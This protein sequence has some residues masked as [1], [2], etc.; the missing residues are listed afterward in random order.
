MPNGSA[1]EEDFSRSAQL[2]PGNFADAC[3]WFARSDNCVCMIASRRCRGGKV[4]CPVCG[5][6]GARFL[7][8]R[9]VWE[10]KADHP[11]QQ[12]SVR[13]GTL[14]EDLV[15]ADSTLSIRQYPDGGQPLFQ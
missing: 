11:R 7:A 13:A 2:A 8:T 9:G 12:F 14:L 10:C 5:A 6:E 3:A 4:L 1:T 15:R